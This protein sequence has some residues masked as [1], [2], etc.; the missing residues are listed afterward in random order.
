R[1]PN[2]ACA[3]AYAPPSPVT[4][5]AHSAYATAITPR[6][7]AAATNASGDDVPIARASSVGR[8]KMPEPTIVL[9][10]SAAMLNR[11][12]RGAAKRAQP[13]QN[14]C[15]AAA[16]AAELLLARLGSTPGR[17]ALTHQEP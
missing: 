17:R 10:P 5:R 2:A 8:A 9:I 4:W 15:F 6:I 14:G 1:G 16:N 3:Y 13:T 7:A 11:R 12:R